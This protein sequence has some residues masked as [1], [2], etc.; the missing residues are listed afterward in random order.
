MI[1]RLLSKIV[2]IKSDAL[3]NATGDAEGHA[4]RDDDAKE[5]EEMELFL[6]TTRLG[7]LLAAKD[8]SLM[9]LPRGLKKPTSAK[10]LEDSDSNANCTFNSECEAILHEHYRALYP[11]HSGQ[12]TSETLENSLTS[13]LS[14][15]HSASYQM[16]SDAKMTHIL[17]PR[18]VKV[19]LQR[20]QL[21]LGKGVAAVTRLRST[22]EL[23]NMAS[24]KSP[25]TL[26]TFSILD[27]LEVVIP[28]WNTF[29]TS[30]PVLHGPL[31]SA[32]GVERCVLNTLPVFSDIILSFKRTPNDEHINVDDGGESECKKI[33]KGHILYLT[34]LLLDIL[35]R[36]YLRKPSGSSGLI[37]EVPPNEAAASVGRRAT[38]LS[39]QEL[40]QGCPNLFL[41]H[42]HVKTAVNVGA[43]SSFSNM[44]PEIS[45][46]SHAMVQEL[47]VLLTHISKASVTS[48]SFSSN[49]T[50]DAKD[51]S[52]IISKI[53]LI[54]CTLPSSCVLGPAAIDFD[55]A[56]HIVNLSVMA[57]S[58]L[59][60]QFIDIYSKS[61]I[62]RPRNSGTMHLVSDD[63]TA[64]MFNQLSSGVL[65]VT[66]WLRQSP[67][68]VLQALNSS[69]FI[70]NLCIIMRFIGMNFA[71]ASCL[72]HEK[73]HERDVCF[74]EQNDVSVVQLEEFINS[75]D[76][77]NNTNLLG[78]ANCKCILSRPG[79]EY[80]PVAAEDAVDE[81][82]YSYLGLLTAQRAVSRSLWALHDSISLNTLNQLRLTVLKVF[83]DSH[84]KPQLNLSELDVDQL[85]SG[86]VDMVAIENLNTGDANTQ[87]TVRVSTPSMMVADDEFAVKEDR[88]FE[89]FSKVKLFENSCLYDLLIQQILGSLPKNSYLGDSPWTSQVLPSE[90]Q[91]ADMNHDFNT[92]YSLD[93]AAQLYD[94][95]QLV[96]AGL[97]QVL[98]SDAHFSK[99]YRD[100][101]RLSYATLYILL[102]ALTFPTDNITPIHNQSKKG[103]CDADSAMSVSSR[104]LGLDREVMAALSAFASNQNAPFNSKGSE[105]WS[106]GLNTAHSSIP[107]QR[108]V[109]L[110]SVCAV[111][112]YALR[113]PK[114]DA[115]QCTL[116]SHGGFSLMASV[117]VGLCRG[118][119]LNTPTKPYNGIS[120]ISLGEDNGEGHP[121]EANTERIHPSGTL[122]CRWVTH[123]VLELTQGES[124]VVAI[125]SKH[126]NEVFS[127][128]SCKGLLKVG[129]E[130]I[131]R[132][133]CHC[134]RTK[135]LDN[136]I[137][138]SDIECMQCLRPLVSI[139]WDIIGQSE[140]L[141][142]D[143]QIKDKHSY[144]FTS[145]REGEAP[146]FDICTEDITVVILRCLRKA[147][148]RLR[149]GL[150][151]SSLKPVR[152]LQYIL[153]SQSTSEGCF[154]KLINC[155]SRPWS[156][157]I[158]RAEGARSVLQTLTSLITGCPAL[159]SHL[160][161]VITPGELVKWFCTEWFTVRPNDWKSVVEAFIAFI[162]EEIYEVDTETEMIR[163]ASREEVVPLGAS[164]LSLSLDHAHVTCPERECCHGSIQNGVVLIPLLDCLKQVVMTIPSDDPEADVANIE[165][166]NILLKTLHNSFLHCR[167]SRF[168]CA[169]AG[170]F[171]ALAQ[172]VLPLMNSVD[173]TCSVFHGRL[174]AVSTLN[175]VTTLMKISAIEHVDIKHVKR[176]LLMIVNS[177]NA[178]QR[179]KL[180]LLVTN[181]LSVV[182]TAFLS[183]QVVEPQN[184]I[185][186]C[187]NSGSAGVK[188]MIQDN[189][190]D[191]YSICLWVRAENE[192]L[193][194][195]RD[196]A[197]TSQTIFS[198]QNS[199]RKTQLKLNVSP[200]TGRL[201]LTCL[202]S[203]KHIVEIDVGLSIPLASWVHLGF[204]HRPWNSLIKNNAVK[205][206]TIFKNGEEQPIR[207]SVPYP[208]MIRG[209]FLVGA[210]GEAVDQLSCEQNLVGQVAIVHF[211]VRPLQHKEIYQ[212]CSRTF[213]GYCG[214]VAATFTV[215]NGA[216]AAACTHSSS[217]KRQPFPFVHHPSLP[218]IQP[219]GLGGAPTCV[220]RAPSALSSEA[221]TSITNDLAAEAIICID[222]R[223]GEK[224]K[225]YNLS[226]L[227]R[228]RPAGSQLMVFE[229]T[230]ICCSTSIIDALYVLGAVYTVVMPLLMLLV[231]SQLPFSDRTLL[232]T[233]SG[234][235]DNIHY[236][237]EAPTLP[238]E[239][240]ERS[241]R[242]G[243]ASDMLQLLYVLAHDD[244]VRVDM[245]ESGLFFLLANVLQKLGPAIDMTIPEKILSF[246]VEQLLPSD[247]L[248][249]AAYTAFFLS[250][251]LLHACPYTTQLIWINCQR[252]S[253]S[254]NCEV[255]SRIRS[256]GAQM[257]IVSEIQFAIL[258]Y[259]H[260]PIHPNAH[261]EEDVGSKQNPSFTTAMSS[262][263][264]K[265]L[266]EELFRFFEAL[267][268]DPITM[269]DAVPILHLTSILYRNHQRLP[270]DELV[271][272]L[273]H[274]RV[275]LFTR[276]CL[277]CQFLGREDYL[278][279][280]LPFLRCP[281][282]PVA[283][284]REVLL[285]IILLVIRSKRTQKYMNPTLIIT[286][287][288][289]HTPQDISLAWLKEYL[290]P[291]LVD[292][293]LYLA[294][295]STLFGDFVVTDELLLVYTPLSG[296]NQIEIPAV[297]E[298]ILLLIQT[299]QDSFLKLCVLK[300]LVFCLKN[301]PKAWQKLISIQGWHVLITN[302]YKYERKRLAVDAKPLDA[303]QEG[304]RC[305]PQYL[306]SL[307]T[308]AT[309]SSSIPGDCLLLI[310]SFVLSFTLSQALMNVKYAASEQELI[311]TYLQ[312]QGL[313]VLLNH[314]LCGVADCLRMRLL[315]GTEANSSM[316]TLPNTN[317]MLQNLTAFVYTVEDVLFY[318]ASR[319]SFYD[320]DALSS[321][322]STSR[323]SSSLQTTGKPRYVEWNELV[324][325][326]K[327]ESTSSAEHQDSTL[328]PDNPL[329]L[330]PPVYLDEEAARYVG[331]TDFASY[332]GR[333]DL[334]L[335]P[336][337]RWL[338]M[339]LALKV[340]Y[341]LTTD[342]SILHGGCTHL[343]T[344]ALELAHTHDARCRR[345]GF[346]R[347]FERLLRVASS[348]ILH[349]VGCIEALLQ[350]LDRYTS[351][352]AVTPG[353]LLSLIKSKAMDDH[354]N[355]S[356]LTITMSILYFVHNLLLR[357]LQVAGID[358]IVKYVDTNAE[359]IKRFRRLFGIFRKSFEK[360]AVFA[361]QVDKPLTLRI[362]EETGCHS[363][364]QRTF[365]WLCDSSSDASASLIDEFLEVTS[366]VDYTVFLKRC[367]LAMER[368]RYEAK[369]IAAGI[370]M[371]H[372]QAISRLREMVSGLNMTREAMSESIERLFRAGAAKVS[373]PGFAS[374]GSPNTSEVLQAAASTN[375]AV[376][377]A[378]FMEHI[379][380][381]IWSPEPEGQLG[382]T[383]YVRLS[384]VEQQPLMRCKT[385]FDRGGTSHWA[386]IELSLNNSKSPSS[387]LSP[388][389]EGGPLARTR[390]SLRGGGESLWEQ[391]VTE[392]DKVKL[393][394]DGEMNIEIERD[395]FWPNKIYSPTYYSQMSSAAPILGNGV[396]DDE[397]SNATDS[398]LPPIVLSIPCE[399]PYMMHCWSA[400]F[401]IRG[402]AISVIVDKENKSYNQKIPPE[403]QHFLIRPQ[404]FGFN[405]AMIAQIAPGRRFRMKR[406][407][408]E[409]WLQ[410]RRS[411]LLNF[412]DAATMRLALREIIR[413]VVMG[414]RLR[415]PRRVASIRGFYIFQENPIKEPLLVWSQNRWR[416]REMSNFDYLMWLN[417]LAGRS[418]NDITQYPV[419][420]WILADYTSDTLDLSNPDTFRDLSKPIGACGDDKR[421]EGI[422]RLYEET[423]EMGDVPSH[424]FTHYSSAAVV[425]YYLMRLEPFTAL[426][427]LL[428][429]GRFDHPDRMF[430]TMSAAFRGVI[431]NMQDTRELI[432]ELFYLPELCINHNNVFFGKKQNNESVGDL[433]LPPWA[434]G[435]P[436]NFVYHMREALECDYVSSMLHHWIDLIFGVQQRGKEAIK[437]LNV[438]RWHS[439]EDLGSTQGS[440]V[441]EHQL[442]D[443]LDNVGQTP[444]QLFR[445]SH[446]IRRP[447]ESLDPLICQ[448]NLRVVSLRWET[449]KRV[450]LISFNIPGKAIVVNGNGATITLKLAVSPLKRPAL[451]KVHRRMPSGSYL[452]LS[453]VASSVATKDL[454][455]T[456]P[457]VGSVRVDPLLSRTPDSLS[458]SEIDDRIEVSTHTSFLLSPQRSD[459]E[460]RLSFDI[461]DDSECR[462]MAAP[463]SVIPDDL[464]GGDGSC[465]PENAA[466]LCFGSESFIALGGLFDHSVII[467]HVGQAV[468]DV[469]LRAHRGRVTRLAASGD[470]HYL[471]TGSEDTTFVVWVCHLPRG[472]RRIEVQP[473]FTIYKHE[474][475]PTAVHLSS[476]LDVVATAS[477][478]GVL[479]LNSLSTATLER[480]LRH[481]RQ[482]PIH[483]ILVQ[484]KCYVPN[485][486][487]YSRAD[488]IVHQIC[489]N[490]TMLRS[491]SPPG[492]LMCWT[493]TSEQYL[494]MHCV[495]FNRVATT[496][497]H[498]RDSLGE[499]VL[500]ATTVILYVH[501]FFMKT[502][503][504]V[505]L[506]TNTI[507]STIACHPK[508]PQAVM[509]GDTKGNIVL[510]RTCAP[511]SSVL[512]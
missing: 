137:E 501:S 163:G 322:Q 276:N 488:H 376:V 453:S 161:S 153:C 192:I 326:V 72:R 236:E 509:L 122:V 401:V 124:A 131:V 18:L 452:T 63:L 263:H 390:L 407:A 285:Q 308:S 158:A 6:S 178:Q 152:T 318:S 373:D 443:I 86:D 386:V 147:L 310:C 28:F 480:T 489:L 181:V 224:G 231:N 205:N 196:V 98:F 465:T 425:L 182:A 233:F 128:L 411:C 9:D 76:C 125:L 141:E 46:D 80:Y 356:P 116:M 470:S 156:N 212:L 138:D 336:D 415:D 378:R 132:L 15:F 214:E 440:E 279:V 64:M 150:S 296:T 305:D 14:K 454:M 256:L 281:T 292:I 278:A 65:L 220:L 307:S 317:V 245:A 177:S 321:P 251:N 451:P 105:K 311:V 377:V 503:R 184:Y 92:T 359:L 8:S 374:I 144:C 57:L 417:L 195:K 119:P 217:L 5:R 400:M 85:K 316:F 368:N 364:A 493:T 24:L 293:S 499:G 268:V 314:V 324:I 228:G 439:Y 142:R 421:R 354:R 13:S 360:M 275:L 257:F 420:P 176:L 226:S 203:Q 3:D 173:C 248:F 260:T 51:T 428:Q 329:A 366:R 191:G 120:C 320:N 384:L 190:T 344:A 389:G 468:G 115:V 431:S 129:E 340:A 455:Q 334:L 27:Y 328:S 133:L 81:F 67:A 405:V 39:N 70:A 266:R 482:Y 477:M 304:D 206:A 167:V 75:F 218:P 381:T 450:V 471:V 50:S 338:H 117:A 7:R 463:L 186:F 265:S 476:T 155:V 130:I 331:E 252:I 358:G 433:V 247:V 71:N 283:A 213:C 21:T 82:L 271:H 11:Y 492:R 112:V 78:L 345:G 249:E 42:E 339:S 166:L 211:F 500:A 77:L 157:S 341:L 330:H 55:E 291:E 494:L 154:L 44:K 49:I 507:V 511:K 426:Y 273:R 103:S 289:V 394:A 478:D 198:L 391:G 367:T 2:S 227:L 510:V 312:D 101:P 37:H 481:P 264:G 143:F 369:T 200:T 479:M 40:A 111:L 60:A 409:I 270:E 201:S 104:N 183:K 140:A 475:L 134:S 235:D 379:K 406:T 69:S 47:V 102:H 438:F 383:K 23:S 38:Q 95:F 446:P 351:L 48:L 447:Q 299:S 241:E 261:D 74:D 159:R 221:W 255:R 59:M 151:C 404:S 84:P 254:M 459:G 189:S 335:S 490:G 512:D 253:A 29:L 244:V 20:W 508:N 327:Q 363:N 62:N 332:E 393:E 259:P 35:L 449:P 462:T 160:F 466:L 145:N 437:A 348:M 90:G 240:K 456:A 486:L 97:Y 237:E 114:G 333:R 505:S 297:L 4:D 26:F 355:H 202:D 298:L 427:I 396:P 33:T 66:H 79:L 301:E 17:P 16:S 107:N 288:A 274:I 277:L 349:S 210:D 423:K 68:I 123:L 174:L 258:H 34:Q 215:G 232:S 485:I 272:V 441:D 106:L 410:N 171:A 93:V 413:E 342:D 403:A 197:Q 12:L 350:L 89:V 361:L 149:C 207:L 414:H 73:N 395:D 347:I 498:D 325:V 135:G 434:H 502:L 187:R 262:P 126:L 199:D 484:S 375:L 352:A 113:G 43:S 380:D 31:L 83:M 461:S 472:Q 170:L 436:H 58:V 483:C 209:W 300:D 284:R 416:S 136:A 127:F 418:V 435:S 430:H 474:D 169:Q 223:L 306:L 99:A 397:F 313:H 399:M 22:K 96:D 164:S 309:S 25:S 346:L 464:G 424:Y 188:A 108:A 32:H 458:R 457:G 343:V 444:I 496:N 445:Q 54:L 290:C 243:A 19:L 372:Q 216:D 337:G 495:P 412:P 250:S 432:P 504:T 121:V 362:S 56:E 371:E 61:C 422:K 382:T 219:S 387:G 302:I 10:G 506:P 303:I 353:G 448:V 139:I 94:F 491:F 185:A 286:K 294:L 100:T 473:L 408:V 30:D 180:V 208:N 193:N 282:V 109:Y 179:Q 222:P 52:V 295:R 41:R 469:Y 267:T 148:Y 269:A 168:I 194:S 242:N 460:D 165:A 319:R 229:A 385:L 419:F 225:L 172:L 53:F 175:S 487:F 238:N 287:D 204:V 146:S 429:G 230:L 118:N 357:R 239:D 246:C 45:L 392:D 497:A 110:C 234:L 315:T 467:R 398:S 91:D 388:N 36:L 370:L 1:Y 365:N 323:P 87:G 280:L 402:M 88:A 162:Y 442:L